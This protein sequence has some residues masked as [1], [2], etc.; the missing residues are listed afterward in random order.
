MRHKKLTI[1]IL[2]LLVAAVGGAAAAI[3]L[4]LD[5]QVAVSYGTV[6]Y[7]NSDLTVTDYQASGPGINIDTVD[8]T[9]SNQ[10]STDDIDAD[11]TVYVMSGD[12]VVTSGTTTNTFDSGVS[13]TVTV[14][15]DDKVRGPE[16]DRIDIKLVET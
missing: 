7:V 8:V 15:L 11:V 12:T 16:Y 4:G 10:N 9:V 3:G 1:L 2:L 14:T 5:Q 13:E 6:E